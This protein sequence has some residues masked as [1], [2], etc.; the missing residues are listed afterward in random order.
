MDLQELPSEK[1]LSLALYVRERWPKFFPTFDSVAT[2]KNAL[3]LLSCFIMIT[4]CDCCQC[5]ISQVKYE[6]PNKE[7]IWNFCLECQESMLASP[8]IKR[9]DG[10]Q[11]ISYKSMCDMIGGSPSSLV[12]DTI[13]KCQMILDGLKLRYKR[14]S[15]L[16]RDLLSVNCYL[17]KD[18]TA[19]G[20]K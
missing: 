4:W 5:G 10:F 6:S 13:C 19:V 11:W 8:Q 15:F 18:V 12:L 3:L 2:K 7:R 20:Q 16:D 14:I 1:S 17:L 9:E